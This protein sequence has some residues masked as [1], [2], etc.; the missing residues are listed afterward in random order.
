MENYINPVAFDLGPFTIRWYAIAIVT[1][2]ILAIWMSLREA[3]REGLSE[4]DIYDFILLGLPIA[5]VGARLYYVIFEW[6]YYREHLNQILA[7]W[8]GGIAIYGGLIAG[9]LYLA[10]FCH[11]RK[12]PLLKYLDIVAPGVL[13]AQAIGRWGNFANHEAFGP[14]VSK[15]FLVNLHLPNFIIENMKVMGVYHQP[16]FLYESLW[17]FLGVIILLTYRHYVI[18]RSYGEIAAL[19]FIWY[20]FGRFFIEGLRMDSL[21]L[22]GNI[23]VSQLLSAIIFVIGLILYV[24]LRRKALKKKASNI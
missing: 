21:Y 7:I 14:A 4:D 16:T 23:R 2:I 15:E 13:L 11:R 6:N 3:K 8:N 9:G 12:I 20:S 17:S 5:F 18:N 10:Y 1:G 24:I 22:I 19:Y